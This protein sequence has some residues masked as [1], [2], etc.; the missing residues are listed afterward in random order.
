MKIMTIIN[1]DDK[2]DFQK[3]EWARYITQFRYFILS[4][5]GSPII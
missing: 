1:D 4:K 2:E 3:I 5:N